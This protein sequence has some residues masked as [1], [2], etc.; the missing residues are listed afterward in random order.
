MG[1]MAGPPW[2]AGAFAALMIVTA[3]YSASRLAASHLR[4]RATET[5]TDALHALMGAAMAGMLVPQLNVLPGRAWTAVF[6]VCAAWFGWH[7]IRARGPTIPSATRCRFPVPHLI[8]C[9]AMLY[10]LLT[11]HDSRPSHAGGGM[12]MAGMGAPAS[13]GSFPVLAIILAIFMLGYIV[14]TT[15]R[16]TTLARARATAAALHAG[17]NPEPAAAPLRRT[18]N[19]LTAPAPGTNQHGELTTSRTLAPGLAAL[20]KIAMSITMGYMLILM[21]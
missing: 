18:D 7:A 8:E 17:R 6:G 13:P 10:M 12:A 1:G 21:L 15:D 3:A 14:W 4:S 11:V 20:G 16:L 9:I 5:D 19:T 2:L